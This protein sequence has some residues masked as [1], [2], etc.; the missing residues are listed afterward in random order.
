MTPEGIGRILFEAFTAVRLLPGAF[1]FTAGTC[2]SFMDMISKMMY[3]AT[4]SE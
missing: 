1:F 2:Q 4:I 3:N